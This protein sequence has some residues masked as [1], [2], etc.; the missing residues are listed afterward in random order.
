MEYVQ[1]TVEELYVKYRSELVRWCRGM[2]EHLQTAE[3]IIQE[4]FVRA[5]QNEELFLYMKEKQARAWLYRTAKNIYVDQ[6]RHRS[7]ETI[8]AELPE[9]TKEPEELAEVE[10]E[11]LL[12]LLPDEEGVIFVMRYLEGYHAKQIGEMLS[13]PPGTVRFKLHTARERLRK[14]L[15]D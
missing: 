11:S 14:M 5:M 12:D 6:I 9:N 15:G 10:W 4:T 2:T 3:E 1:M 13:M 8:M 7:K